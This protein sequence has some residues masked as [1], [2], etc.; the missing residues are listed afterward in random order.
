[1]TNAFIQLDWIALFP[2]SLVHLLVLECLRVCHG[3]VGH[4]VGCQG[5][6]PLRR[7]AV[8]EHH[9]PDEGVD[10][11]LPHQAGK[12]ELLDNHGGDTAQ[13]GEAHQQSTEAGQL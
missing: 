11:G 2:F 7:G 1:M 12:E 13:R 4:I 9:V 3:L 8:V 10:G 5:C 6:R